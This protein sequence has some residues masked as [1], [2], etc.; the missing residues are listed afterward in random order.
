MT[1]ALL[2]LGPDL[3]L[4]RI[5]I[6]PWWKIN[7]WTYTSVNEHRLLL[8]VEIALI[9]CII[10]VGWW[11]CIRYWNNI[12]HLLGYWGSCK[13]RLPAYIIQAVLYCILEI[14]FGRYHWLLYSCGQ[15]YLQLQTN[16]LWYTKREILI[17]WEILNKI[18]VHS[19]P[20]V[21]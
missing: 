10:D 17:M 2:T 14:T 11:R 4:R 15:L 7:A 8:N 12:Y 20:F 18:V 13:C 6:L 16:V 19:C 1:F 3:K 21:N 5:V 9:N